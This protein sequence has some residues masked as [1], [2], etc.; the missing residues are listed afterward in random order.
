MSRVVAVALLIALAGVS[1]HFFSNE[2]YEHQFVKFMQK[3]EKSYDAEEF[4]SRYNVFKAN[5]DKIHKHN[6]GEHTYTMAMNQFGDMTAEEFI[7]THTGFKGKKAPITSN[8]VH[9]HK[10]DSTATFTPIDWRSRAGV[11][12]GVKDQGQCGSCWAF[13]ATGST[14]GAWALSKGLSMS[15]PLSEQQ[16]VD[17]ATAEGNQGCEGG[18]MDQAFQYIIDNSGITTEAAY[19][20]TAKDGA[21]CL[22][23]GKPV[24][25]TISS[26]VDVNPSSDAA[27]FAAL[28]V[29]PVSIAI[30]ADQQ[31][32]QFYSTGIMS[33]DCGA[34]LDHGVLVVAWGVD[35]NL[36][37]TAYWTIKNSWGASWGEAG[38]IRLVDNPALNSQTG[39]CGMLSV[40]SYPVV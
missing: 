12:S 26:F 20:Y 16:L 40:P 10:H 18:L 21:S 39:Q 6:L 3:H 19:P 29:G 35:A 13:S 8:I 23:T 32:F 36:N 37:S 1:A 24:A 7:A 22:A 34:T 28:Q 5:M 38:Y 9:H 25:S 30:E 14:E 4:F 2:E 31:S 27:L 33:G 17:C 15:V 11:V